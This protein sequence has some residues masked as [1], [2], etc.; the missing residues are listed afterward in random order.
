MPL[1]I[2]QF[3]E[4]VD[5]TY[6]IASS[7]AGSVYYVRVLEIPTPRWTAFDAAFYNVD[8]PEHIPMVIQE[9]AY[10]SAIW[11]TP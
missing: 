6:G 4:M 7:T 10:S 2:G 1:V 8:M 3:N 11:Y 9:R 5:A